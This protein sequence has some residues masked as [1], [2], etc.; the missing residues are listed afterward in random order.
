MFVYDLTPLCHPQVLK[1]FY[2][3][4]GNLNKYNL[5]YIPI[6][7]PRDFLNLLIKICNSKTFLAIDLLNN[8]ISSNI[9]RFILKLKKIRRLVLKCGELPSLSI[10]KKPL[11]KILDTILKKIQPNQLI[12]N[13][14][15]KIINEICKP[16]FYVC[17]GKKS[18]P[19]IKST[20][21]V[22]IKAHSFDY[23]K[24]EKSLKKIKAKLKNK[25]I[26]LDEDMCF[27]PD[28]EYV[29]SKPHL[30]PETYFEQ[31]QNTFTKIERRFNQKVVIAEHPRAR[32]SEKEK[33]IFFGRRDV[34]ANQTENLV[35]NC[36]LILAHTST[37]L[38]FAVFHRKPVFL[39]SNSE[40]SGSE[41]F[42]ESIL[43]FSKALDAPI[44]Y[45]DNLGERSLETLKPL[46]NKHKYDQYK[47]DY[48]REN[49]LTYK[50]PLWEI[51]SKNVFKRAI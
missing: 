26:F 10:E 14:F 51:I 3:R 6:K 16:N 27:H 35:K 5:N 18:V 8:E 19:K 34:V 42:G 37:S 38:S 1:T 41:L 23:E 4:H 12:K 46:V 9:V 11:Y 45:M 15:H 31:L 40:L 32:Y 49:H 13:I 22:I 36:R 2:K 21:A 30:E 17:A 25:I 28:Y 24:Q 48:I 29:N 44:V 43:A 47:N 50:E 20:S 39:L 33:K 7:K